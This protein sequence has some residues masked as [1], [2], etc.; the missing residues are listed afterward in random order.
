MAKSTPADIV[1]WYDN[2]GGTPID[3]SQYC[4]SIGGVDIENL[5]EETHSFGDNWE[6]STPVGIGKLGTIEI[7][8]LYDDA[9]AGPNALFGA[10]MPTNPNTATRT[11]TLEWGNN[12]NTVFETILV[13]YSR[14]PDRSALTKFSAS[15]QPTG[16]VVENP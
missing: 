10:Q 2:A 5:V 7:S 13:K 8:G 4:Q 15:L 9:A 11:L 3:I 1:V 6:E 14:T 12:V 16:A